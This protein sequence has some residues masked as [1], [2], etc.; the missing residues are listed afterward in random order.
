[1]EKFT[2]IANNQLITEAVDPQLTT[3]FKKFDYDDLMTYIKGF[4]TKYLDMYLVM[5]LLPKLDE[6]ET[7]NDYMF[8]FN[9]I[10]GHLN[11]SEAMK[12]KEAT[13]LIKKKYDADSIAAQTQTEEE[14][15]KE[16]PA[17]DEKV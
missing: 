6:P 7:Y 15:A 11:P 16:Q 3:L 14:K 5:K 10:K 17:E 2:S 4:M 1:M 12:F 9:N 8:V 13:K